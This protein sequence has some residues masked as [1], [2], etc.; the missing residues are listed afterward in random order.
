MTTRL[1]VLLDDADL[2]AIQRLA[3]RRGLTTAEWVRQ[4]LRTAR[5]AEAGRD[6]RAKLDAIRVAARHTFPTG[7]IQTILDEIERG[8]RDS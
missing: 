6:P 7:D 8:Y 4:A 2:R 5:Q 1:Q 3:K